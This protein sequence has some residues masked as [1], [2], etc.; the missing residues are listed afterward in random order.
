MLICHLSSRWCCCQPPCPRRCW[1]SLPSLCENQCASW[2]RKR[3]SPLRVFV[4]STSTLKK[5]YRSW[6]TFM[7]EIHELHAWTH[8]NLSGLFLK[9]VCVLIFIDFDQWLLI[10][11]S[12]SH[13]A[14][15]CM[16]FCQE[17]KLDTLCDLYETLTITQA[18]I[19]INTRRKVDWLTEKMHARDFTVSAL[20]NT[21]TATIKRKN[22]VE[23]LSEDYC[24]LF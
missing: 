22:I 16:C 2:W 15:L 8:Q 17:W 23:S 10:G 11:H 3:S 18:V 19:F 20:V 12:V 14:L 5:R 7:Q 24:N 6:V 4:S 21:E 9:D 13:H 1:M